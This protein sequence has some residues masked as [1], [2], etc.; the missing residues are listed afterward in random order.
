MK[1][2]FRGSHPAASTGR[3]CQ[4]RAEASELFARDCGDGLA[5]ILGNL[6]Q[7]MFG[8]T[9][10]RTREERAAHPLYFVISNHPF[11]D[12]NK[13]SG[14]FLFLHYRR[15]ASAENKLERML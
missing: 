5:A 10:Y 2:H 14:A 6:E 7:S 1:R 11:A 8:E 9:L 13:R 12:G 4:V 15:K 3:I